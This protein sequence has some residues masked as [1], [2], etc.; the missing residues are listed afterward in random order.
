[1]AS[2]VMWFLL[3]ENK[4]LSQYALYVAIIADACAAYPTITFLWENPL[5]DR[6]FAWGLFSIGYGIAIF[7]VTDPRPSNYILPLYMWFGSLC[8]TLPLIG[9][10]IKHKIPLSKWI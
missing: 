5:E 1:M 10:R 9:Y 4:Y 2:L 8:V 3:S 6:P 7:A